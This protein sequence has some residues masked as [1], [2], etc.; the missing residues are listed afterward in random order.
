MNLKRTPLN[1]VKQFCNLMDAIVP[2]DNPPRD[3]IHLEFLFIYCSV[4]SF[5]AC[6]IE[7]DRE[8]YI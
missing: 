2:E 1:M 4:W 8:R 7:S 5:G 3:I 6:L